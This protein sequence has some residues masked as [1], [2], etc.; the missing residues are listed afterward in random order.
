MPPSLAQPASRVASLL[1]WRLSVRFVPHVTV[2]LGAQFAHS[3]DIQ[4]A[5]TPPCLLPPLSGQRATTKPL[6]PTWNLGGYVRQTRTPQTSALIG[7]RVAV[8]FTTAVPYA[9][10]APSV[11]AHTR[12]GPAP[13]RLT[14][15]FSPQH[16]HTL[17]AR[18]PYTPAG[19]DQHLTIADDPHLT[20]TN[21]PYLTSADNVYITPENYSYFTPCR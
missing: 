18:A 7:T 13:H 5:S 20:K 6:L 17:A 16:A 21:Y 2:C 15:D 8:G 19:T 11:L 10:P 14:C 1:T 9:T 3:V 12:S 4:L